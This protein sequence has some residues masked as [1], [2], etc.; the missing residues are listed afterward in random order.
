MIALPAGRRRI[1]IGVALTAGALL[2]LGGCAAG[3]HAQTAAEVPAV[4]GVTAN[5][6]PIALRA[7]TVAPP[8]DK[9][10]P[11][12]GDATLQLVIV[13]DSKADDRLVGV[14]TPAATEGRFFANT[15]DATFVPSAAPATTSGSATGTGTATS[16]ATGTGSPTGTGTSTATEGATSSPGTP[17]AAPTIPYIRLPAGQAVS[18]G[19][20]PDLPVIQLHGLAKE[21]FP[22]Q[23]I[24]ITFRFASAGSV[25]FVIAVH[26]APGPPST[27]S[28]DVAPTTEG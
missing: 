12:G 5:A 2:A 27:P 8:D 3:Q 28:V 10:Y 13:N 26:L 16:G 11:A 7:V 17:A 1:G 24:P 25:T 23:T 18:I 9:S 20:T 6:G 14:S 15:A 21:L 19:Y 22:A 4:D